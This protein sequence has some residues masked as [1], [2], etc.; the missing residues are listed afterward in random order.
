MAYTFQ[1]SESEDFT[2]PEMQNGKVV[3]T[4]GHI[5]VKPSGVLW[6]DKGGHQWH[7]LSIA[8]FAAL[9]KKHGKKQSM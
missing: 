7:R 4:I 8:E 6:A 3:G 5:R 9:A 1:S 2:I